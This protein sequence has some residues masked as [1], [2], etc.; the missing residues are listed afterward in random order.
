M[1][2]E[3]YEL[4]N[5]K[6]IFKK[7]LWIKKFGKFFY[8]KYLRIARSITTFQILQFG[9]LIYEHINLLEFAQLYTQWFQ[10]YIQYDNGVGR[11]RR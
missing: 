4:F 3:N 11:R 6:Y 10:L 1:I 5:L 7:L 9:K 2:Y 8:F